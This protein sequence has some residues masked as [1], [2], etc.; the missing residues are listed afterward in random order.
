MHNRTVVFWTLAAIWFF[1]SF[2]TMFFFVNL[3]HITQPVVQ[4]LVFLC[5]MIV[6]GSL[7]SPLGKLLFP[8]QAPETV[9]KT[10]FIK[11]GLPLT[12]VIAGPAFDLPEYFSVWYRNASQSPT[13]TYMSS[14]TKPFHGVIIDFGNGQVHLSNNSQKVVDP[15]D[16][17]SLCVIGSGT[18]VKFNWK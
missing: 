10:N 13:I 9:T 5:S 4:I 6:F 11:T 1:F 8:N 12:G 7:T 14:K 15:K 17:I 18:T 16:D 2:V 3:F